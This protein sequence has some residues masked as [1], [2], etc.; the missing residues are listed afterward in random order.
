MNKSSKLKTVLGLFL[1]VVIL[2]SSIYFL[3]PDTVRIDIE[4]TRTK[5]S[6]YEDNSF[7]LAATEYVNLFDGTKKM[8]AKSR[9]LTFWN[10][11]SMAYVQRRSEWKEGIV[12]IQTYTFDK[13]ADEVQ[14]FPKENKF[15]C[16][17][18]M[19]K[20]VHY[21]VRDILYNGDTK[22]IDS[23][24][25]FGHNMKMEWQDGA[26]YS[27]VFQ[28][29]VASDKIIVKYKPSDDFETYYV[30]LYDPEVTQ[31]NVSLSQ[32]NLTFTGDQNFTRYLDISSAAVVSS[33][34]LNLSG[35]NWTTFYPNNTWLEIGTPDGVYEWSLQGAEF[36]N[37]TAI[38]DEFNDTSII[39]NI[40]FSDGLNQTVYVKLPKHANVT[41]AYLNLSGFRYGNEVRITESPDVYFNDSGCPVQ[42]AVDLDWATY[43]EAC[44]CG[45]FCSQNAIINMNYTVPKVSE[46]HSYNWTFKYQC[47]QLV[48]DMSSKELYFFW[49]YTLGGWENFTYPNVCD[50]AVHNY[51]YELP[52]ETKIQ[53]VLS[54]RVSGYTGTWSDFNRYFEGNITANYSSWLNDTWLEVGTV[55]GI[56]EW[57][58]SG[59]FNETFS[60]NRTDDFSSVINTYLSSCSEDS[61]G[62]CDVSLL[63]H[64]DYLGILQVDD[65]EI[66]YTN[67]TK[68]LDFSTAINSALN[69][70]DCDC[71]GCNLVVNNCSVP[72]TFHSDSAGVL[73]YTGLNATYDLGLNVTVNN[74]MYFW[75]YPDNNTDQEVEAFNQTNGS[76]VFIA[77]NNYVGAIDISAKLNETDTNITLKLGNSSTYADSYSIT[78][79][80]QQLY[81][82]LGSGSTIYLW[83]WADYNNATHTWYPELS[84]KGA[85]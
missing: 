72:F 83:A 48:E 39:K 52:E 18:C 50:F 78:T 35:W 45:L 26:Y 5:Y 60:P 3:M 8:R 76:G 30:R 7:I 27:K 80:Y 56:H 13:D 85:P 43:I 81:H 44:S 74:T 40:T 42:N 65:I 9:E 62:Y 12:T 21:E 67:V 15:E 24:F 84:I 66:N 70:G 57:N 64:S 69:Y 55:D 23:P 11:S 58:F 19:G 16:I 31:F 79:A 71:T 28:Q 33:A 54:I 49:N 36:Q 77:K 53:D 38:L 59:E 61:S 37:D 1:I 2:S 47:Q 32:E 82:S 63:L 46:W 25:E 75:F 4:K 51:D 6:V 20:I 29:K 17:N 22:V 73:N 34:Y 41:S 14:D 68:T 10:D